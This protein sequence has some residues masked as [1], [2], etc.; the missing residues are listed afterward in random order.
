MTQLLLQSLEKTIQTM[1]SLSHEMNLQNIQHPLQ[2]NSL[3]PMKRITYGE[4]YNPD[5]AT[6]HVKYSARDE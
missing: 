2:T 6:T 3:F 4:P 5:V 1:N